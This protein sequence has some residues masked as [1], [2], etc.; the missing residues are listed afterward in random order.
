[1]SYY[2]IIP[3]FMIS[4][5]V[6]SYHIIPYHVISYIVI[7]YHIHRSH[8]TSSSFSPSASHSLSLSLH[9]FLFVRWETR[10][11]LLRRFANAASK[12]IVR[13]RV[14]RRLQAIQEKLRSV[15]VSDR[16]SARAFVER[17]NRQAM[18]G[19]GG[20][21]TSSSGGSASSSALSGKG[22]GGG[23]SGGRGGEGVRRG[24][25][26]QP[27]VSSRKRHTRTLSLSLSPVIL[28][29]VL[30][31]VFLTLFAS[32]CLFCDPNFFFFLRLTRS[33]SLF[34]SLFLF[35]D[36][37][38]FLFFSS[39]LYLFPFLSLSFPGV[40][41]LQRGLCLSGSQAIPRVIHS[42]ACL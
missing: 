19:G 41:S 18:G 13:C 1:M 3:C 12:V 29:F 6:I 31:V 42:T 2:H 36:F 14:Q 37:Y 20:L 4:Y 30:I 35:R 26:I 17:D 5:H 28:T 8:P 23:M 11:R 25:R 16:S 9:S 34:V 7:S 39:L 40:S 32:L 24:V 27:V 33:L 15:G 10:A 22:E 21:S 38:F